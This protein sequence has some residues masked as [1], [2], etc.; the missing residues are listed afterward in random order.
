MENHSI[1]PNILRLNNVHNILNFVIHFASQILLFQ[2]TEVKAITYGSMK[3]YNDEEKGQH[4]LFVIIDIWR[5]HKQISSHSRDMVMK[6][7][8]EDEEELDVS[9]A[10]KLEPPP[11]EVMDTQTIRHSFR[12]C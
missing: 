3:V 11:E 4:E 5:V 2:G 8:N 1:S 12:R 9:K 6:R 7:K 10:A